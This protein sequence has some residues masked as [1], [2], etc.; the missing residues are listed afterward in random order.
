MS[1][2]DGVRKGNKV[3]KGAEDEGK[4]SKGCEWGGKGGFIWNVM[5]EVGLK[6]RRRLREEVGKE[7]QE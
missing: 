7:E 5:L 1:D 6:A 2:L 3:I 4:V